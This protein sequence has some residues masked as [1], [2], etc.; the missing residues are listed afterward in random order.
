VGHP[1]LELN[2]L[3]PGFAA[4]RAALHR[5]AA[6]LVAPARERATGHEISL[7]VL[8]G[9]F[10]TPPGEGWGQVRVEGTD[11]VRVDAD[12]GE[13]R[14]ALEVDPAGAAA[15]AAWFAYGAGVLAALR[16]ELPGA[17]IVR[18]WPEHFDVAIEAGPESARATFGA[19]PGDEHHPEP[20]LYCAPWGAVPTGPR[21]RAHGFA[22]SELAYAALLAEPAAGLRHLQDCW[23]DLS[24]GSGPRP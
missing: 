14:E 12:G 24:P 13:R 7:R 19:S 17:G 18:L 22:G 1:H 11:L 2:P 21:W 4:A 20:Y 3:P 6:E 16:A 10:G 23:A 8:P 9:G 15:L 5:V